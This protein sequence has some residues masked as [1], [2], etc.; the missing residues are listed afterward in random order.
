[1]SNFNESDYLTFIPNNFHVW[2]KK[3]MSHSVHSYGILATSL[4][5]E[6]KMNFDYL[7]SDLPVALFPLSSQTISQI[8][9]V[10]PQKTP[11]KGSDDLDEDAREAKDLKATFS[12]LSNRLAVSSSPPLLPAKVTARMVETYEGS[13]E[14]IKEYRTML[15]KTKRDLKMKCPAFFA[16]ILDTMTSSSA[17]MVQQDARFQMAQEQHDVFTL[18]EIARETHLGN[19]EAEALRLESKL[20]AMKMGGTDFPS[21]ASNFHSVIVA[22]E[23]ARSGITHKRIVLIF[24]LSL[25]G[26]PIQGAADRWLD[27]PSQAGF[28]ESFEAVRTL[29]HRA[30]LSQTHASHTAPS[31]PEISY[32]AK[33]SRPAAT[34]PLP[35][36]S[37]PRRKSHCILCDSAGH[38]AENCW[39]YCVVRVSGEPT[40]VKM[41]KKERGKTRPSS[42]SNGSYCSFSAG[43]VPSDNR[44]EDIVLDT[45]STVN[46]FKDPHLF[47]KLTGCHETVIGVGGDPVTV[48]LK[49]STPWGD[50][51]YIPDCLYNLISYRSLIQLGYKPTWDLQSIGMLSPD[52]R[53]TSFRFNESTGLYQYR[54]Q[55]HGECS[56]SVGHFSAEQRRR[57]ILVRELHERSNH[58]SDE[59]MLSLLDS[60]CLLGTPLTPK[61][62]RVSNAINGPCNACAVGKFM[63]PP[64]RPSTSTPTSRPGELMHADIAFFQE[65]ASVARPYLCVVDDYTGF[66]HVSKLP[67]KSA[68]AITAALTALI[69]EFKAW[70][71]NVACVRSDSE[72]VFRSIKPA[73][74][75]CGVQMQFAAPG[76]HEKRVEVQIRYLRNRFEVI[77]A[78]LGF[79]LPTTLYP[80]LLS[81]LASTFNLFPN[82]NSPTRP[83]YTAITGKKVSYQDDM[84][85]GFGRIV[86]VN[87]TEPTSSSGSSSIPRE[88]GARGV[89]AVVVG[90]D[91]AVNGGLRVYI[92]SK[93]LVVVRRY[94]NPGSLSTEIVDLLNK[95]AA[96]C[97]QVDQADR[98]VHI[99]GRYLSPQPLI[100]DTIPPNM[101]SG[102]PEPSRGGHMPL[103]QISSDFPS[104]SQSLDASPP[105][106]AQDLMD[107]T[108]SSQSIVSA[109]SGP[110]EAS[111]SSS[112]SLDPVSP[113]QVD[114]AQPVSLP[115]DQ[116]P[117]GRVEMP[118]SQVDVPLSPFNEPSPPPSDSTESS[119]PSRGEEVPSP[120]YS[121]RDR[122]TTYKNIGEKN[123]MVFHSLLTI[124]QASRRYPNL[125]EQAVRKELRQLCER[126]TFKPVHNAPKGERVVHSSV[127][128]TPK[129]DE[130]GELSQMKGRLVA[131]G[132]EVD[133]TLYT[134]KDT[135]SPTVSFLSLILLLA[136]GSYHKFKAAIG[137][138]DF[139]GAFLFATLGTHRYMWLGKESVAALL[140][141]YPEWKRFV[142]KNG[143]M[144]VKVEGALYGFA[145]SG[146]RWYEL[147]S[148]FLLDSGYSQSTVDPC[149]F[150]KFH[151]GER[152]ML[153][154]HVD[155]ILYVST[156]KFLTD[157]FL[158]KVES[159][160]GK[161]KHKDGNVVPF[162]GMKIVRAPDGSIS[163]DQPVYV[164]DL[165][166]DMFEEHHASSPSHK[167]L[168]SRGGVGNKLLDPTDFRSRVAKV[169]YLATKTRPDLLFTV[170]TLASRASEPYEADVKSLNHLYDY[171]NS[172]QTVPLKFKCNDMVL[173]ASVDASH[174]IHRDNKGHSGLVISLGGLPVFHRSTKQK[175]VSTSAM[176]AEIVALYDS[177]PYISWFRDLLEELGYVQP[178]PTPVQQDNQSSLSIF[179]GSGQA[180]SRKTRHYGNK[181]AFIKEQVQEGVIKPVYVPTGEMIADRLTKPF[182]GARMTELFGVGELSG[183]EPAVATEGPCSGASEGVCR[184]Q[185][186][187]V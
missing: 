177:F 33:P 156:S 35:L 109:V 24:L 104:V 12:R 135:S 61:D 92:P 23:S 128:M 48:T 55:S 151:E 37:T 7:V 161:V 46:I 111:R 155:D 98:V 168:L 11:V 113:G 68:P 162:L 143:T 47:N 72:N 136:A 79:N 138:V 141:D 58:P 176:Q 118:L 148:A 147:L 164:S 101:T 74:N 42:I 71:H 130:E 13:N 152:I 146:K 18:V 139:P 121:R 112:P 186:S 157:E 95:R 26:S 171:I 27:D 81:H 88:R 94:A 173:S 132:N 159:R 178:G 103:P 20:L 184:C 86:I 142:K 63:N 100:E 99:R 34:E 14:L 15:M 31:T 127:V 82:A 140:I 87:D 167:D 19:L 45:G 117:H 29:M 77:K 73:I 10:F 69:A 52:G 102:L 75:G 123:G 41:D 28:P 80:F 49:G 110:G 64:S 137:A 107:T 60:T 39:S 65:G 153:S 120:R 44:R 116:D 174:D 125:V 67:N 133:P 126:G 76:A 166:A 122:K 66:T 150:F 131:S 106:P 93:R 78:S 1:M 25:R 145:E 89:V 172:N 90:R 22:L 59:Q 154:L 144:M 3:L 183:V 180:N 2:V 165:V 5:D 163:V 158:Q 91:C 70:G 43:R 115:P 9:G 105:P 54:I 160:F 6:S 36:A 179:D 17:A 56:F 175:L 51:L 85:Y 32:L 170:S 38:P 119:C 30:W 83:P 187:D 8:N 50:A 114:V 149:I 84:R 108:Q 134:R 129:F 96:E 16:F 4:Q 181:I 97:R 40:I 169:M 53:L 185:T 182:G 62:I 57:A 21:Y 124:K